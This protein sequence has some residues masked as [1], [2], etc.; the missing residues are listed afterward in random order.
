MRSLA[1]TVAAAALLALAAVAA[2]QLVVPRAPPSAAEQARAIAAELRC[3]DCQ[4][5]SVAESR[6]AAAAAIRAEIAEQLAAGRSA[7][8]IRQ[9]FVARYGDWILL[10]P[11]D[12]LA[13]WLPPVALFAGAALFGWWWIRGRRSS[14]AAPARPVSDADRRRVRDAAEALDD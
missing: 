11:T 5:L 13:W 10:T 12:P 7:N 14:V 3:P 9:H 2:L 4:A 6:T 1:L 8:E